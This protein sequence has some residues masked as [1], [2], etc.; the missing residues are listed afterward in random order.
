MTDINSEGIAAR[1]AKARGSA[2]APPDGGAQGIDP[3]IISC[4]EL[5]YFAYRDFTRDPDT[6]CIS[7]IAIPA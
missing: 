2:G 4:V 3:E 1:R 7:F 6:S 5:F